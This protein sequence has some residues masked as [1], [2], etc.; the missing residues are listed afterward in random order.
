MN[1]KNPKFNERANKR[2]DGYNMVNL[3]D[4][5]LPFIKSF[6]DDIRLIGKFAEEEKSTSLVTE[7]SRAPSL[8]SN[9]TRT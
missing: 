3:A 9:S 8:R 4:P 5:G 6:K 1:S 7:A 2:F